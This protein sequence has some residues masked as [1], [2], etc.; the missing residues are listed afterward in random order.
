MGLS[1]LKPTRMTLQLADR[2]IIH[3]RGITKDV[4]VKV[5]KLIFPIDFMILDVNEDVDAPLF[6]GRPFVA[7]FQALIDVSIG[8]MTPRVWDKEVV[9]ALFDA[10]TP[11]SDDTFYFID[12]NDSIIDN[13][14]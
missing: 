10:M 2:S 13:F 9:F 7:T 1:D 12:M 3:L 6:L 5:D 11:A 14:V 8:R 4:L